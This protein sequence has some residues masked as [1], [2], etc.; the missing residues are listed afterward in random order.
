M[1][2]QVKPQTAYPDSD[3]WFA[4]L[5]HEECRQDREGHCHDIHCVFCGTSLGGGFVR[6]SCKGAVDAWGGEK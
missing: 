3:A 6:C 1:S 2:N 5:D 4:D